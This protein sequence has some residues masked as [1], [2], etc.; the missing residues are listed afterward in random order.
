MHFLC[1]KKLQSGNFLLFRV[2]QAHSS[3]LKSTHYVTPL[4]GRQKS[5]GS[6]FLADHHCEL[7]PSAP[8]WSR[9]LEHLLGFSA[10]TRPN[11]ATPSSLVHLRKEPPE[12]QIHCDNVNVSNI[13]IF[14]I[15]TVT[16]EALS[17]ESTQ[18]PFI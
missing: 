8:M 4:L 14:S 16:G 12:T 15:S 13:S 3:E 11:S 7:P 6:P 17:S 1:T 2:F 18:N 5:K 9:L 10:C